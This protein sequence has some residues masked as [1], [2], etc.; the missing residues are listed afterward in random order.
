MNESK[1]LLKPGVTLAVQADG[2]G[3]LLN[4]QARFAQNAR[5]ASLLRALYGGVQTPDALTAFLCRESAAL[6][7]YDASLALADFILC[8]GDYLEE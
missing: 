6:T 1:M 3:L 5:Q 8:F 4:G 2:I 7:E